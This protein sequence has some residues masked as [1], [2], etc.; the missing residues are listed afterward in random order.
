MKV[1]VGTFNQEKALIVGA[2]SV[3]VKSSRNLRKPSFEA[4]LW[5]YILIISFYHRQ[6]DRGLLGQGDVFKRLLG[7]WSRTMQT[8]EVGVKRNFRRKIRVLDQSS[9][10]VLVGA[11]KYRACHHPHCTGVPTL[12]VAPPSTNLDRYKLECFSFDFNDVQ[13]YPTS[14]STLFKAFFLVL[15]RF[16]TL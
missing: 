7:S 11:V 6:H 14:A 1:L 15:L 4:L 2:F 3:T 5:N 12:M 10:S 13:R 9:V 8:C 16:K